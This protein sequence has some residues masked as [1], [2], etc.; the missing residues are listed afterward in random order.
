MRKLLLT[1]VLFTLILSG[2][3]AVL[4]GGAGGAGYA[5]GTDER[6]LDVI[7]EDISTTASVKTA[8]IKDEQIDAFDINVDTYRSVVTL[9]GR[10]KSLS[11]LTR[12][13]RLARTISGVKKVKS[14]LVVIK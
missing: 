14:K 3:A 10:V 11:Q 13:V 1:A 6:S 4:V 2:C 8:L 12:A 7:S 9:H 5:A